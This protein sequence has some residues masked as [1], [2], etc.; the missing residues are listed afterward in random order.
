MAMFLSITLIAI[1]A[2]VFVIATS[3]LG[4][5]IEES[6]R[7][8]AEIAEKQSS[9][10]DE[11]IAG[12]QK[13]LNEAKKAKVIDALTKQISEYEAKKKEAEEE[14][15]RISKRYSLLTVRGTVLY[16]GMFFLISLILAGAARYIVTVP[17][18]LVANAVWGLALLALAWG[19]YR[20][21]QCLNVIQS[22]AITTEEAQ[23]KKTTQALEMAL[24]QHEEARR[25][26]LEWKFKKRVPPFT[27]KPDVKETIEF[28]VELKQGDEAKSAEVWFFA[29]KG[30][31]FPERSTWYQPDDSPMPNTLTTTLDLGN[32][33]R[34]TL[35]LNSLII[36]T[37]TK[38]DEYSLGYQLKCIGFTH[39]PTK[40][41]VK[42][43]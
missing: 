5:A 41:T 4:R 17:L 22:I 28:T 39:D 37:P 34:G 12:L 11:T 24:E 27:F 7:Q 9:E 2:T 21:C 18:V 8:Q 23:F 13:E 14:L 36:K 20:I 42:V 30:F 16:P 40:F 26:K 29:P 3:L 10:F 15:E 31:E 33:K 6:S 1:V 43:E 19:S 35:Y 38:I 32:L 25:P